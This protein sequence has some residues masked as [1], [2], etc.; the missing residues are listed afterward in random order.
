MTILYGIR[1]CDTV[2][3]ARR[4]LQENDVDYHFH[5]LREDGLSKAMLGT[6][7]QTLD[8]ESLLNRRGTIWRQLPAAVREHVDRKAAASLMLEQPAIIKRPLLDHNDQLHLGFSA[9]RYAAIFHP[10]QPS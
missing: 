5:D 8:W 9:E 10:P 2:R 6:W 4:W 3:K 7:M 1:N